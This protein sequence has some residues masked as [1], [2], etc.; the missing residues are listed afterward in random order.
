WEKEMAKSVKFADL[1]KERLQDMAAAGAEVRE[2]LRL[3]EK[4]GANVVGQCLA[5]QGTFY[6]LDH[7]PEGD[8]YDDEYASQYYYHSHREDADEHGHFHTFLRAKAMP[9]SVKPAPY[10][11]EGERPLGKDALCHF[12]AF[13]MN[14]PGMPICMF[15]TNRWVTDETYYSA[16]DTISMLDGFKIDHTFPCLATNRWISAMMRLFRPQIENLLR[17]RD[18][19]IAKW[20]KDHPDE[21][22]YED[23]ELEVTSICK[24][25]IDKQIS[26]VLQ[27]LGHE[28]KAA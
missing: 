16:E 27:A 19:T 3:L 15:T 9:K 28:G 10:D 26:M 12:V 4:A 21:D 2:A 6:E 1:P 20:Q 5:N 17:E 11:G 18:E 25:N 7:Y 23:R 24:I 22:V 8:V 14:N 13:S